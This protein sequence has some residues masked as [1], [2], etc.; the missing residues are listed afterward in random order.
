MQYTS[1]Y[2]LNKPDGTDVVNIADLNTNADTIDAALTPTADPTQT[3]TS[4]GPGK[5]VQW[6]S[7]IVNRIKAITGK[8]NW[9]EA[10]ATTLEAAKAHM[11]ATAPHSGHVLASD[12]V[13]SPVANKV[14]RLNAD[15]KLPTSITGDAA[16]VGG[17]APTGFAPASHV[18]SAG[19][20]HAVAT[21]SAAG[22]LSAADKA[23]LDTVTSGAEVNQNAFSSVKAVASD[24]TTS[25]GQADADA[26]T[27]LLTL[28]EGANVSLAVDSANDVITIGINTTGLNA[29]TIDGQHA[30]AFAPASHVGTGGSAHAAATSSTAGFMSASDK[31]KLDGMQSG[32]QVNQ[33]AFS[34]V[35]VNGTN[36]DA[37]SPTDALTLA[38]GANIVLTPDATNDKVTIAA[39]GVA[40]AS[41]T[42]AGGDITSTVA[43]AA[44]ADTLDGKHSDA[45]ADKVIAVNGKWAGYAVY[46]P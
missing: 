27:D 22:F 34:R 11:D 3:P 16:T 44:N 10:P 26:K 38:A 4:N 36:I 7:W 33:N 23:K 14:L 29:D 20:A 37:D 30:S 40:Q 31:A 28:K 17:I 24:G 6:V 13:A 39:T 32:A 35:S 2:G 19:S 21:T 9:Y 15:A 5:L 8:A 25:R 43:S 41:H 12:V 18:G 46:A 1:N 42:H 45:F